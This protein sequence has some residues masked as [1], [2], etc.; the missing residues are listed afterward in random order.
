MRSF[1]QYSTQRVS[2]LMCLL[3]GI[4]PPWRRAGFA[5]LELLI[6]V[7]I[8]AILAA[9]TVVGTSMMGGR[10][11][12]L[13]GDRARLLSFL[14]RA[15]FGALTEAGAWIMEIDC[16]QGK[17]SIGPD[18]GWLGTYTAPTQGVAMRRDYYTG[19]PDFSEAQPWDGTLHEPL[20]FHGLF[21]ARRSFQAVP[22]SPEPGVF[23]ADRSVFP[24]VN[25]V[26]GPPADGGAT[27]SSS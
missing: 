8:L 24:P 21:S 7:A 4:S 1:Q 26:K 9:V 2:P 6:A 25:S 22:V 3:K 11:A 27:A 15:R 12:D 23:G 14:D 16:G 20:L 5:L 10:L 18:D 17:V 13:R 19:S